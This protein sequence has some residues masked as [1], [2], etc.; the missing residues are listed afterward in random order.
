MEWITPALETITS[1]HRDLQQI[2][3][4]VDR[5]Y[6]LVNANLGAGWPDLDRLLVRFWESRSIRTK[7]AG[8]DDPRDGV[9]GVMGLAKRLL[10]E[11]T[12]RGI[13]DPRE[14]P[15]LPNM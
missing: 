13:I 3:V 11:S 8:R 10:P 5:V 1:G 15:L 2:S 14:L 6:V 7:F 9:G 12:R 4:I